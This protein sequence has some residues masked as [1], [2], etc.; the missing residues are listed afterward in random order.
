MTLARQAVKFLQENYMENWGEP[1]IFN[2][3][4]KFSVMKF[5]KLI[6][7]N[8]QTSTC[9]LA[10]YFYKTKMENMTSLLFLKSFPLVDSNKTSSLGSSL[11]SEAVYLYM[12]LLIDFS[13]Q[14][15]HSI[16]QHSFSQF[17]KM[18]DYALKVNL[19]AVNN[20]VCP[21]NFWICLS[22]FPKY[23]LL[24]VSPPSLVP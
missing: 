2:K 19:P 16:S 13:F 22:N 3:Y 15:L 12:T 9:N 20:I 11:E 1:D 14:N 8:S 7:L 17:S 18:I 21:C 4:S 6:I 24:K 23:L 10:F 5:N